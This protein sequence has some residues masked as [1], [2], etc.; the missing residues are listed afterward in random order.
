MM[1][2]SPMGARNVLSRVRRFFKL[3]R[4]VSIAVFAIVCWQ[5]FI[6]PVLGLADNGDF[7]RLLGYLDRYYVQ[8]AAQAIQ[9]SPRGFVSSELA[10]IAGPVAVDRIIGKK[11]LDVIELG[12]VHAIAFAASVYFVLFASRAFA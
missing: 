8:D 10:F 12:V 9:Y 1:D 7:A 5:L 3:E 2:S 11:S 4:T 6:P